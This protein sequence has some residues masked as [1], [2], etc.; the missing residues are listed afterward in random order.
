MPLFR[1][2]PRVDE[3]QDLAQD[4]ELMRAG[5]AKF[6]AKASGAKTD[7]PELG[8]AIASS[9]SATCWVVKLYVWLLALD[10]EALLPL[11]FTVNHHAWR[12]IKRNRNA[13]EFARGFAFRRAK[14]LVSRF[15]AKPGQGFAVCG[16]NIV[17][18]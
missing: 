2:R 6:K 3:D 5:C 9:N 15:G 18:Q 10:L 14:I 12:V 1:I 13:A 7:R 8:K 11:L 16:G 4:A 17:W